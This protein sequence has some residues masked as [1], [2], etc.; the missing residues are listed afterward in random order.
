MLYLQTFPDFDNPLIGIN[1][2]VRTEGKVS[3][4]KA[5]SQPSGMRIIAVISSYLQN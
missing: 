5:I 2:K 3:R 4:V 1:V